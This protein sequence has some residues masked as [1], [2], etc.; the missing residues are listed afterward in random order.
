MKLIYEN[1]R[2]YLNEAVDPDILKKI[3]ED[4]ER[5]LEIPVD[6]IFKLS[7]INESDGI[8]ITAQLAGSYTEKLME[9]IQER[10]LQSSEYK[11][12]QEMGYNINIAD[13]EKTIE[14]SNTL[15]TKIIL[16]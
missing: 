14:G 10:W 5:V 1:W 9:M 7:S 11:S 12:L 13:G 3:V 4:V 6:Q 16:N 2:G 8:N 15:L